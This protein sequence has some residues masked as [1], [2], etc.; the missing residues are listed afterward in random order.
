M[1]KVNTALRDRILKNSKI[2]ETAVLAESTF[3]DKE[4]IPTP[5]PM[6]NAALSGEADGGLKAGV[7]T[8]AGPSKHFKTGFGLL[9]ISSF[10]DKYP[11]G[12]ILFYDTEFGAPSSYFSAYGI[13]PESVVHSPVLDVEGLKIDMIAQLDGLTKDDHVL[14]LIDSVGNIASRKELED[15]RKDNDASDMGARAKALKSF[16]RLITPHLTIKDIPLI[17]INHTYG[18]MEKYSKQQ[19][20]GGTG[21]IYNS[22]NIW[23]VGRQ[24]D[25]DGDE[26][27]GYNFV[28]NVEKSR[29]VK[30]KSKFS[31]NV[32]FDHGINR[33]SGLFEVAMKAGIIT[34]PKQGWY[35]FEGAPEGKPG[36]KKN[37]RKDDLVNN[38]EFWK[39]ILAETNLKDYIRELYQLPASSLIVDDEQSIEEST[40][41]VD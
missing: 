6:I 36:E 41:E 40:E 16:W 22:D 20:S 11:D 28:I 4:C 23:I 38:T 33:W 7:L 5:V 21:G 9:I 19:V 29:Y 34:N 8:I 13:P 26:L 3:F 14:I 17:A 10:L 1:T 25:K 12:V 15:A 27:S 18:T 35:T 24:Q 32:S 39:A 30:E 37:F 2:A 31:I